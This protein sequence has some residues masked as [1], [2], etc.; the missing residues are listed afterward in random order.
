ML[1]D[2]FWFD[3]Y[4]EKVL[5][6]SIKSKNLSCSIFF[7]YYRDLVWKELTWIYGKTKIGA[8]FF[9][10][11]IELFFLSHFVEVICGNKY[12]RLKITV[13]LFCLR[14]RLCNHKMWKCIWCQ[15]DLS[16]I[17]KEQ[18]WLYIYT[19]NMIF[20]LIFADSHTQTLLKN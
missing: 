3:F 18:T 20:A 7:R 19:K 15:P 2:I 5:K 1:P 8:N 17:T 13:R 11:K 16:L 6:L 9:C 4:F 14:S 12:F 10:F